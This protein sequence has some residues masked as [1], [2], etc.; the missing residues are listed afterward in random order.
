M[1]KLSTE[2]LSEALGLLAEEM[3]VRGIEPHDLVVCGGSALLALR[4]TERTTKDVDILAR[5]DGER[6]LVE[7]R[8]LQA[9]LVKAAEEVGRLMNLP[10]G[11]LNTGPS[12]QLRAGLPEGCV[13]RLRTVEY[14]PALRV[15]Y[16]GRR[17]LIHLK[18]FALVDQGPG[19]HLQDLRA[20]APTVEEM[21][22]AARWVAGQDEGEEFPGMIREVLRSLGY[23][24]IAEEI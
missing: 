23:G 2:R 6:K 18:F 24:D 22:E 17:D 3:V 21:L 7:P 10:Q 14:G 15:H 11:W 4:I 9:E 16:T 5:L 20:L 1:E 8:P 13:E 19:K 12:D